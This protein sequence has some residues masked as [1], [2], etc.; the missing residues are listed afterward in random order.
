MSVVAVAVLA[1]ITILPAVLSLF[2]HWFYLLRLPVLRPRA[3]EGEGFWH[4]WA[5]RIMRRPWAFLAAA[6]A[7]L[8]VLAVPFAGIRLGQPG[9]AILPADE[10]PRLATERLAAEFGA[11][12]TGPMEILVDTP[13]GAGTRANLERVDRLTRALAADEAAAGVQSLTAVLPRAD[14]ATYTKLYAGGLPGVDRELAPAVA[15]I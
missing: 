7:V 9:A 10:S 5:V 8:L 11:G 14:L 6:L 3:A 13:G 2:V 4:R 15:E 1:A 12:V